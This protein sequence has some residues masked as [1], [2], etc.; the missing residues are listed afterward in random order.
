MIVE[1]KIPDIG[2]DEVD[3]TEVMVKVGDAVSVEQPL[4]TVEG[5]KASMEIPSP[6]AGVVREIRVAVGDKVATGT[7]AMLF[8]VP[9]EDDEVNV[10][11]PGAEP[12]PGAPVAAVSERLEVALPDIGDDQ[13]EVT[14]VMVKVGDSVVAEQ[15][16]LTIEGDK[17]SME[18]PAPCAGVVKDIIVSVGD[19]V[20][21]GTPI[22]VFT[23]T[24]QVSTSASAEEKAEP[25]PAEQSSEVTPAPVPVQEGSATEVPAAPVT[26]TFVENE[27][28]IHATPVIRRLAREFGID[29]SAVRG[30][31]RKRRILREDVQA[32]VKQALTKLQT[33]QEGGK[34][35]LPGLLPWPQVDFRKFGAVEEVELGKIQKIS[36][37][38]LHR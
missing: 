28:Y 29:L 11:T 2:T 30:T 8:D 24:Q 20:K 23:V 36:G 31:G 7:L 9:A 34:G 18:V 4:L 3:V 19:K 32:Y 14:E 10:A 16:L 35:A 26:G 12:E 37:A 6:Q 22:M 5:D 27:A 1:I 15:S 25:S 13:V 21:T 17:A 38:N 33:L